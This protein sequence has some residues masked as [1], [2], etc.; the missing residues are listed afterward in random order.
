MAGESSSGA[1]AAIER[2]MKT[3]RGQ[4]E[5]TLDSRKR[6]WQCNMDHFEARHWLRY[7]FDNLDGAWV[8]IH[9]WIQFKLV[10]RIIDPQTSLGWYQWFIIQPLVKTLT[11]EKPV[12]ECPDKPP[13]KYSHYPGI[14]VYGL[15]EVSKTP[16]SEITIQELISCILSGGMTSLRRHEPECPYASWLP[17]EHSITIYDMQRFQGGRANDHQPEIG[18]EFIKM[19][20]HDL[21][22]FE[23][24]D[25]RRLLSFVWSEVSKRTLPNKMT[26][27]EARLIVRLPDPSLSVDQQPRYKALSA[28]LCGGVVDIEKLLAL[29]Y[30]EAS[31][32]GLPLQRQQQ[33]QLV[34]AWIPADIS[35]EHRVSSA[36]SVEV[37][38][39]HLLCFTGRLGQFPRKPFF[40]PTM[41]PFYPLPAV[42]KGRNSL[43]V[44]PDEDDICQHRNGRRALNGDTHASD[45]AKTT[46]TSTKSPRDAHRSPARRPVD[47]E[48]TKSSTS[49]G[50]N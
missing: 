11:R 22:K 2:M 29:S 47:T 3:P 41:T 36:V 17:R 25:K 38:R 45:R 4:T 13:F 32:F 37:Q 14:N 20:Q 49:Q 35:T 9:L 31:P 39:E 6:P 26:I 18:T 19:I 40:Y 43:V 15:R 8:V 1:N 16:E 5:V 27:L 44:H 7:L 46:F 10:V 24:M 33:Q 12:Q 30:Q 21:D 23:H 42:H 34:S 50:A 48:I 28:Q